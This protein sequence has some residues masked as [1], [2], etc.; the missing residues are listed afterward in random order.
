MALQSSETGSNGTSSDRIA[1]YQSWQSLGF[2][3]YRVAAD[4]IQRLLPPSLTVEEFD[5]S[6]WLGIVPFSMEKVRPWWSPP[7]PGISWFLET[8][9]RTYVVD[10]RGVSGVWFFSLDADNWLAVNVARTFW[11]LPYRLASLSLLHPP[12]KENSGDVQSITFQGRCRESTPADYDI[13][14]DVDTRHPSA[15]AVPGTLD[16][17][18]VERYLLFATDRRGQLWTGNVHHD[19]YRL[20]SVKHAG[21]RQ[22]LTASVGIPLDGQLPPDHVTFSDG[23]DVR[24]SPLCRIK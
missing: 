20:R 11:H 19:P 17:F 6:A 3:H 7:I 14:L 5:G 23:V 8:N 12:V 21:I 16:H 18:L 13:T 9:V 15:P 24:V 1:G 4:T 22:T 2:L 10:S